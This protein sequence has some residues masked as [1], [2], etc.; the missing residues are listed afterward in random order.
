MSYLAHKSLLSRLLAYPRDLSNV[1]KSNT[2]F[3]KEAAVDDK[4]SLK[5]LRGENS[6]LVGG[7]LRR[8]G[9]ADQRRERN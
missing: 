7:R 2:I 3:A 5:A 4:V 9:G 6:I 8:S 1:F